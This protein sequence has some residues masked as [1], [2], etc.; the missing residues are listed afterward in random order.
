MYQNGIICVKPVKTSEQNG[1]KRRHRRKTPF[2]IT[3]NK[4]HR[5][6]F[7]AL[8]RKIMRG[9]IPNQ[10][11]VLNQLKAKSSFISFL[12]ISSTK[13]QV[14]GLYRHIQTL[15]LEFSIFFFVILLYP[16]KFFL[17]IYSFYLPRNVLLIFSFLCLHIL[18][19]T[20]TDTHTHH[21]ARAR[22]QA[23]QF[24]KLL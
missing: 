20:N 5:I 21:K 17:I 3:W 2:R 22:A 18:K 24:Y 4:N 14:K 6:E 23:I 8:V 7:H 19:W 13:C 9:Q 11:Y 16:K 12:F 15:L 1:E 10:T